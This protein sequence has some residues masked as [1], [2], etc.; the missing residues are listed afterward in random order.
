M[1]QKIYFTREKLRYIFIQNDTA[2]DNIKRFNHRMGSN[3]SRIKSIE[4]KLN[5]LKA[6]IQR[7][8][9]TSEGVSQHL[10]TALQ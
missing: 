10:S 7:A 1:E 5:S 4:D 9:E 6:R 8:R 3:N 2:I